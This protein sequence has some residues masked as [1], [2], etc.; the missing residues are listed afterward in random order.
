VHARTIALVLGL[1]ASSLACSGEDRPSPPQVAHRLPECPDIDTTICDVRDGA[2]QERMLD[3]AV[4]VYGASERPNVPVRVVTET[5]LA[6]EL[7]E[8]AAGSPDDEDASDAQDVPHIEDALVGLRLLMPGD[9]T[10]GSTYESLVNRI[11]GVY[12]D[13]KT[14]I[15]LVDRG[16]PR[17]DADSDAVLVHE[18]V[19]AIQDAIYDLDTWRRQFPADIDAVL[20]LRSVPEGQATYAQF[21][22]V[23]AMSGY[24]VGKLDLDRA[25]KSFRDTLLDQAAADASPYLAASTSF[26]YATGVVA[27]KQHWS[28]TG[29]HFA[30][31]QFESPPPS[32]LA[33]LI[34]AYDLDE[35]LAA[36]AKLV[37]PEEEA[38]F[39]F[40]DE[41]TLGA[42]MLNLSL[43]KQRLDAKTAAQIS[44]DWRADKI[45]IYAGEGDETA[46]I[47]ELELTSPELAQ[48]LENLS[49]APGVV[50]KVRGTRAYLAGG[51]T[52][53]PN[54][55]RAAGDA[56]LSG[57]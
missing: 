31:E 39:R 9:L 29:L 52:E 14:G 48:Y 44:L 8:A 33:A 37:T 21:R 50:S 35:A 54:F 15:A 34:D 43:S 47:W 51:K 11:D 42:F 12:Q 40:V 56:F 55:L 25:V 23:Y 5:R 36:D 41:T 20:A 30:A 17:N 22:V 10:Q 4:C 6:Q 28:A 7:E 27:A 13:A 16:K 46:W 32:T 38:P 45:W 53:P 3:L 18:F 24:D 2:C 26:P 57:D 49:A 1:C 19:H